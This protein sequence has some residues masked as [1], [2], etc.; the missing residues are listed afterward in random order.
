MVLIAGLGNPGRQY[1]RTRHNAGF[2]FVDEVAR[3]EG[4]DLRWEARF[5]GWLGQFFHHSEAVRLFKPG[6]FMN[7]SGGPVTAVCRY[8]GIEAPQLLVAHDELDFP[9]GEVRLKVDGGHGGHNGLRSIVQ[10]LGRRDFVR[11]RIGIGRPRHGSV[12][13]YVLGRPSNEERAAITAA[14]ARA[15]DC[16][17]LLLDEG[18][19]KAMNRLHAQAAQKF[20]PKG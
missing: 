1:E 13:D 16:L 9:A 20:G 19:E 17:P 11:L 12:T 7:R 14:I 2:W 4:V 10:H 15:A 5:G 3:R 8:F 18:V 6:Q